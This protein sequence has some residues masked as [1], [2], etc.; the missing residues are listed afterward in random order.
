PEGENLAVRLAEAMD[1]DALDHGVGQEL[2][3][4]SGGGRDHAGDGGRGEQRQSY[5]GAGVPHQS[6]DTGQRGCG[7]RDRLLE[8]Q[9]PA[10]EVLRSLVFRRLLDLRIAGQAT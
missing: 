6:E 1:G 3:R 7:A 4:V 9:P 8:V 5:G 10:A 2:R